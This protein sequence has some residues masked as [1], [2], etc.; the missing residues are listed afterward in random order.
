MTTNQQGA[1]VT[2]DEL[3]DK[4]ADLLKGGG[5]SESE[6]LDA[7]LKAHAEKESDA[8]VFGK[9]DY[10]DDERDKMAESGEA[11]PDGRFPIKNGTDLENAVQAYGRAKDKSK[12]KA[13]IEA[14]AKAL[15]MEDKLPADWGD[16]ADKADA[17]GEVRKDDVGA[18]GS[19]AGYEGGV[20]GAT[21]PYGSSDPKDAVNAQASVTEHPVPSV[22]AMV[23]F[24]W[25]ETDVQGTI[26]ELSGDHAMIEAQGGKFSVATSQMSFRDGQGQTGT[27][28][29]AAAGVMEGWPSEKADKPLLRGRV[30]KAAHAA[31]KKGMYGVSSL[32][33]LLE[34]VMWLQQSTEWEAEWEGDGSTLPDQLKAW[35]ATGGQ[36]LTAMVQEE[37]AE[38]TA[39]ED[40]DSMMALADRTGALTKRAELSLAFAAKLR[41]YGARHSAADF[42]K[43]QGI[44]DHAAALG[45]MCKSDNCGDALDSIINAPIDDYQD[46]PNADFMDDLMMADKTGTLK[47]RYVAALAKHD[48]SREVGAAGDLVKAQGEL[49]KVSGECATLR[50]RVAELE[51]L[52]KAGAPALKS[53]DKAQDANPSGTKQTV[54]PVKKSDGTVDDAATMFKSI[55]QNGPMIIRP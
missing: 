45:A 34:E 10:T 35:L 20:G 32:A 2:V 27:P 28:E 26:K 49:E 53:M 41:K 14:R 48:A 46:G 23:S 25:G 16:G 51:A 33:C 52:P 13:H 9:K 17:A 31:L 1:A 19:M 39:G 18:A 54:D 36:I 5:L 55:H 50:K 12:A 7:I 6:M 42:D 22:G 8:A 38:M 40:D 3:T 15:D 24:K 44:H 43:V 21:N 30:L 47:K 37:V 11:M 29:W 4:M